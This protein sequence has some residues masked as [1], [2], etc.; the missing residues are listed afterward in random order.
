MLRTDGIPYTDSVD[1]FGLELGVGRLNFQVRYGCP[2]LAPRQ[3]F[4][5][6]HLYFQPPIAPKFKL[7]FYSLSDCQVALCTR[8]FAE[9]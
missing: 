7:Y 6:E 1:L 2:P 3:Q 8:Y 9:E 5:P 4:P